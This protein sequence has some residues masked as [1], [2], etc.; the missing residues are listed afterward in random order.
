[1]DLNTGLSL[2]DKMYASHD[3]CCLIQPILL[4]GIL[5][6]RRSWYHP[7]WMFVVVVVVVVDDEAEGC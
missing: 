3:R 5:G 4:A 6:K 1:M 2:F 7:R